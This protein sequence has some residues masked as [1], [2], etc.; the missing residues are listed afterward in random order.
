M[1]SLELL[2]QDELSSVKGGEWHYDEETD[3]WYLVEPQG[4]DISLIVD[5]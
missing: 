2:S 1:E 5:K 3:E 4:G